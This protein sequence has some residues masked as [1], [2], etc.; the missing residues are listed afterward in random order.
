[1][2]FFT[3]DDFWKFLAKR[4]QNWNPTTLLI[5]TYNI[6]T[7]INNWKTPSGKLIPGIPPPHKI[8]DVQIVANHINEI[9]KAN[10]AKGCILLGNRGRFD[11]EEEAIRDKWPDLVIKHKK[12]H[13]AK[14]VI[15][16]TKRFGLEVFIGSINTTESLWSDIT[17]KHENKKDN[18]KIVKKFFQ[19][20]KR[21]VLL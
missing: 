19:W 2:I 5:S 21:A 9:C 13:H 4:C 1:M 10:P 8:D 7:G 11:I 12:N 14:C 15:M 16:R 3:G 18:E 20:R 17:V 6:R